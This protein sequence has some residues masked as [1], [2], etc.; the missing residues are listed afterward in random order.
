MKEK[1][2]YARWN[3]KH[4]PRSDP[5]QVGDLVIVQ[6][7]GTIRGFR[8]HWNGPFTFD[9]WSGPPE[10]KLAI[11]RDQNSEK[12][13][14][15]PHT[16]ILKFISMQDSLDTYIL[17]LQGTRAETEAEADPVHGSEISCVLPSGFDANPDRTIDHTVESDHERS[18]R[19]TRPVRQRRKPER[20]RTNDSLD[21][22]PGADDGREQQLVGEQPGEERS[23]DAACER[24]FPSTA[25]GY[26]SDVVLEWDSTWGEAQRTPNGKNG[27]VLTVD[28]KVSGARRSARITA[29]A[30][31]EVHADLSNLPA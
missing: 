29:K 26:D 1:E 14:T 15:R 9:G 19:P 3:L 23:G 27:N 6:A 31:R 13:W 28:Q 18:E 21:S 11:I 25:H 30:S 4:K 8:R 22:C 12:V 17:P 5:V 16:E 20:F 7:T 24:L 10:N 2:N